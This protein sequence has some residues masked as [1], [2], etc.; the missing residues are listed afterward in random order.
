MLHYKCLHENITILY[1]LYDFK[2]TQSKAWIFTRNALKFSYID[3][4]GLSI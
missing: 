4:K 1:N 3:V 2:Q